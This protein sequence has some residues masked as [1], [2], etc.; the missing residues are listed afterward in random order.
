MT[1]KISPRA[2]GGAC[3]LAGLLAGLALLASFPLVPRPAAAQALSGFDVYRS[4]CGGCHE[5]YDPESPKRNRKAWDEILTRMVKERGASLNRQEYTAVLNY[6]DS[7]NRERR[8][9]RWEEGP[10]KPRKAAF[11]PADSGK[12]PPEWVDLTAGADEEIPWAVQGGADGKT[13]YV[14]P[15]KSAGENQFPLLIDNTGLVQD[16]GATARMQLVSG[17]G[18]VGA[19]IVFGFRSPQSYYG[20]RISPRDVVLYEVQGG[21]RAL[22]ARVPAACALKQWHTLGVEISGKEVKVSLNG[23]P[24]PQMTRTISSYR[25]GRLGIHTQG[26]TVAMFDQWQLEAR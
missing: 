20:V 16:G 22:L 4:N 8:E 13:A 3:G 1:I 24:L 5:L 14:Q 21:Q 25:G 12:L 11:N 18:A 10:A 23:K 2:A 15:L 6:L 9:I 19:G 26:D 17:K 7:F